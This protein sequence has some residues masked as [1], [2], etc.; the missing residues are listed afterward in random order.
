MLESNFKKF[1]HLKI[2]TQYSICEGAIK[3]DVLKDNAKEFKIKSL[4]LCDTSN[5]CGAIE[6]SE[7]SRAPQRFE[8]S[9]KPMLATFF[10]LQ[11]SFKL[12]ILIAPSHIEY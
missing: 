5:L 8:V 2:H 10:Y 9:D 11:K 12:S 6:F 1:N 4:G 3:I 7:N